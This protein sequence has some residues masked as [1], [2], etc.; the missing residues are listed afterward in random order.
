MG[1]N[2]VLHALEQGIEVV[3]WNRSQEPLKE[4]SNAGAIAA[5]NIQD[6][7]SKLE[8]PKLVI[9][10]LPAGDVTDEFIIE[11]KKYVEPNDLIVDAANSFYKDTLRRA[12]D[13]N[14]QGIH[15][16]D[17]GTSGGPGGAR[18][19][20]C[21]MIGGS[22]EDYQRLKPIAEK[23]AAPGAFQHLGPVGAGHFAKMVHNGI[24]YGMMQ[25]LAEGIAVLKKAQFNFD[26]IQVMDLYNHQSVIT[27]RLVGWMKDALSKEPNLDNISSMIGSGGGGNIRIPG[28]ADWTVQAAK[29]MGIDT[30]VIE[31][32]I[33]A[34]EESW[35]V[36]ESSSN[37]FR[38]KAV[39]AM[40]GEFGKHA[41]TK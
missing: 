10:M 27:S 13:L 31:E 35:K 26:L 18:G 8:S 17:M 37:G 20:A 11:L 39:S 32:S 15:F 2:M 12:E 33:R 6:L 5:K 4:V 23:L 22:D 25:A 9:L 40:R 41:V 16:M 29:E 38:N 3:A 24:E 34:R 30:P 21:L 7:V 36:E 28:E 19:G 1:K 14:K